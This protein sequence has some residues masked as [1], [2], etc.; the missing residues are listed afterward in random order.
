MSPRIA[1]SAVVLP[2]P[3]GP[4]RPRMRP[5]STVRSMPASATVE[6]YALRRP[7]ASMQGMGS[8]LL[9]T[10]GGRA[11]QLFRLEAEP[12][13]ACENQRPLFLEELLPLA[14]EQALRRAGCGEHA[15]P[16]PLLDQA[17]VDELLVGLEHGERIDAVFRRDVTHR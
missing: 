2:A 6:P 10:A 13:D 3:F 1:F 5:V 4:I 15:K 17:V 9:G 14:G 7:W 11:Q 8:A 12:L 16:P